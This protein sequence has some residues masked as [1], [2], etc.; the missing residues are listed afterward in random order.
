MFDSLTELKNKIRLGED[1]SIE[2]KRELKHRDSIA[3]EIAAFANARGGVLLIGVD[4]HGQ[5]VGVAEGE[6]NKN[7]K[8][9][10]KL[11]NDSIKPAIDVFTY[12]MEIDGKCILKTEIPRSPFVHRSPGGYFIRRASSKREL[13]PSELGQ[14]MQMRSQANVI[15]FDK[16]F[17]PRTSINTLEPHLYRRFIAEDSWG[18]NEVENMLIKRSLL[19]DVDGT[20]QVSVAGV[21]MCCSDPTVYLPHAFIQAVYYNGQHRDAN[22]QLDAKDFTGPLDQQIADAFGFVEKHNQVAARKIIGREDLPQYNM[23]AVFEAIVN[24]AVH[25]DYARHESKIR[26]HMFNNRIELCSPG[27]LPNTLTVDTLRWGQATRNELLTRL[28]SEL[29][30]E[31]R[32]SKHLRRQRFL[33]RRGEGV[34]IILQE[35]EQLSGKA[36]LYA[37]HA[38]ELH[39]TIYAAA[40]DTH[41][42]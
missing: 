21:L 23:R 11:C 36:P 8:E 5:I 25:R 17:V 35:S 24:A 22:Y 13:K 3:D 39:L 34:S 15:S 20:K 9:I 30:L 31:D 18:E 29:T 4:D 7:E 2:L 12:K 42:E 38:D 1:S 10:A 19:V 28:L 41:S 26:L 6:L 14:L 16:Q 32:T 40:H 33:E 27:A 37:M